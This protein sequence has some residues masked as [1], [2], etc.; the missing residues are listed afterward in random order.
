MISVIAGKYKGKKLHDVKKLKVRPTQA[1]VRKSIFQILEPF[2]S[3]NILDL[4]AGVGTLGIEAISR[5][6]SNVIFVE[7]NRSVIKVLK[8]N[9]ELLAFENFNIYLSDV[10]NFL[11]RCKGL[12]FDIVFADP[13]YS[14]I[15]YDVL[16]EA[17]RKIL[18][19]GGI[20]C[21]E[22]KKKKINSSEVRI[23]HYGSTQ[24]VFWKH[25]I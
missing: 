23:K 3:L 5:G 12:S 24:V 11:K 1:K 22:M 10:L 16:K 20:F 25:L 15:E 4:Y 18:K 13:P 21:M 2:E 19:P 8:K 6:A 9:I 7:N 14:D 17:V